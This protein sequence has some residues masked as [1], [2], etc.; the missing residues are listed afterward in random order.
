MGVNIIYQAKIDDIFSDLKTICVFLQHLVDFYTVLEVW[1][2]VTL[3]LSYDLI[4][5]LSD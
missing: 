4:L 1:T 5:G 3:A 2:V